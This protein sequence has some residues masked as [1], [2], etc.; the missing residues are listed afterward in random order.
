[1]DGEPPGRNGSKPPDMRLLSN[2]LTGGEFRGCVVSL[3]GRS[4]KVLRREERRGW[5]DFMASSEMWPR[6]SYWTDVHDLR[7]SVLHMVVPKCV[8]LSLQGPVDHVKSLITVY[9]P[10][11]TSAAKNYFL[12]VKYITDI[13]LEV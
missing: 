2:P 3:L 6:G 1:M 8:H 11:E 7:V 5:G 9:S 13:P 12:W 10:G 4:V